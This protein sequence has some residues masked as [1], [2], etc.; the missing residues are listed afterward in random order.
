MGVLIFF[1]LTE[2]SGVTLVGVINFLEAK[3]EAA[4]TKKRANTLAINEKP[5]L[6]I[7]LV[8]V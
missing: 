4:S 6:W 2:S 5:K 1:L 8:L 7:Q 3:G